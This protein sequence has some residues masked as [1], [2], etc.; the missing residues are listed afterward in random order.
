MDFHG[1]K[2]AE[3][4]SLWIV[5][6]AAVL[7]FVYGYAQQ[8]FGAMMKLFVVGV[9]GAFVVTVPN[10]PHYN[11]NPITWLPPLEQADDKQRRSG[12]G[13]A[14]AG[15]GGGGVKRRKPKHSGW[16]N[17]WGML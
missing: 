2:L 13:G 6:I 8:D 10:W 16:S 7:A 3:T 12:G 1:Q 17:H 4:L 14:A 15:G 5:T 9:A 11:K